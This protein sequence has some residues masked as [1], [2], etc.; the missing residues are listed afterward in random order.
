MKND[1][2]NSITLTGV[3]A[4]AFAE[5]KGFTL[6]KFEDPTEKARTG[7]SVEEAKQI[8]REDSR[9]IYL[10]LDFIGWSKGDGTSAEGYRVEDYFVRGDIYL[11]PDIHGIEPVF[12]QKL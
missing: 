1:N 7:L 3:G 2:P 4:I 5:L 9:L 12:A 10:T 11:G 8:A 6:S